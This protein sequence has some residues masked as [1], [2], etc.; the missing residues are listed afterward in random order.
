[1][2]SRIFDTQR[3]SGGIG[4]FDGQ[5]EQSAPPVV[6][7]V[8]DP[9]FEAWLRDPYAI[10]TVLI[11]SGVFAGGEETTRYTCRGTFPTTGPGDVPANQ[12]YAPVATT[13][14]RFTE[15]LSLSGAGS[16]SIGD[17]EFDNTNS[18]RESW[19]EDDVWTGRA[20]RA[21]MGDR[22]W[23]RSSFR[24]VFNG[25]AAGVTRK[26]GGKIAVKLRDQLQRLDT[27]LT[28]RT[29]G[30][31]SLTSALVYPSCFGECHNVTPV[32]DPE[33]DRYYV[34]WGAI[35]D[36]LEVRMNGM[37]IDD[38]EK[39]LDDGYFKLTVALV[40]V[41]TC[42]VQGDKFGGVY[43]NTVA[44]L[45]QR[46]VTGYGKDDGRFTDDDIDLA[47]FAAFEFAHPQAVGLY[48]PDRVNVLVACAQLADSLGAQIVPSRLGKLRLIQISAPAGPGSFTVTDAHVVSGTLQPVTTY[49]PVAAIK[50][51]F[52]KN[53][54]VQANLQVAIP[55]EHA[56][57]FAE[58]WLYESD[59]SSAVKSIYRLNTEVVPKF[60]LLKT[61][62]AAK[63]EAVRR[64][65]LWGVKRTMYKFEGYPEMLQLELGQIV[66]LR[67]P[68]N[69]MS[70]GVPALVM[71]LS[72][73]WDSGHCDVEVLV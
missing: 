44:A 37:K 4:I 28:E 15:Q 32:Y 17:M 62:L 35:E 24:M 58:E 18:V 13:G 45:V 11:E 59:S 50:L 19:V 34:H 20:Q 33:T 40:G 14:V 63:A 1:M 38:F 68:Q 52:D 47:N 42:S 72:P 22:R 8:P 36:I 25:M 16:A 41:L 6:V 57:L 30:G 46:I 66:T 7:P 31:E 9:E 10:Q 2:T 48:V 54:T 73:D 51:G 71:S 70:G 49:D 65:A 29:F 26:A 55:P 39:F 69:S 3:S 21:F 64:M 12:Y 67:H 43:R 60:T 61:R 53:W 27:P 56:H 23:G 5:V